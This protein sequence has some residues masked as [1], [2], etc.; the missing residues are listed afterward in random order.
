MDLSTVSIE[1]L[2]DE[3]VNR[4]EAI[5]VIRC[6]NMDTTPEYRVSFPPNMSQNIASII[7]AGASDNL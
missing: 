2:T 4:G 5:V 3:L 7:V 1:D 6:V